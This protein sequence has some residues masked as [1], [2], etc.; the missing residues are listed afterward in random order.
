MSLLLADDLHLA[1]GERVIFE[2]AGVAIER[3]DRLGI[4]GPNG[5]G[6]S[7]LLEILAGQMAPDGGRVTRAKGVRVGYLAQE[8]GDPGDG[9]LLDS[10]L[11]TAPGRDALEARLAEVEAE[12]AAAE[13]TDRQ[14]EFAQEL[15]DLTA[16]IT[17]LEQDFA[18]HRAQRILV[19]L[20]FRNSDFD[21]PVSTFSGGWRMRAAL[22]ALLF[23]KP[24]VLLLDEPT[25][26][27]DMP[28][29]AWLSDFLAGVK[30]AVVLT[31]HDKEFLNRHVKRVASLELEGLRL[32]RGNYDEYLE[33]RELDIAHLEARAKKDEARK[34]ELEAFVERFR[35]KNTKARQAQSKLKLIEKMEAEVVELPQLRRAIS[36]RFAP[37]ERAADTVVKIEGLRFGYGAVRLFDGLS[38]EVRRGDRI[39]VVGV[40]GA[41]K[42]TLLELI[43]GAL[44]PEGGTISLGNK[45]TPRFFAQHHTEALNLNRSVLDEI[46]SAAPDLSQTAVRGLSGAFLF[47]GDD[48]DKNIA[49]LS[50]GEK[51]RVALAKILARP[52]NLLLLDEP[53]NH[54]DTESADKLTESLETY[55]GTTIFVSHN[56]DFARRLSNKVWDVHDGQV[57]VYPGSLAEYLEHLR[58]VARARDESLGGGF[59]AAPSKIAPGPKSTAPA[60]LPDDK[61]ARKEA[62]QAQRQ[63]QADHQKKL[64]S[65]ERRIEALEAEIATL[66]TEQAE[67]EATLADPSTHADGQRSKALS[68]RYAAVKASLDEKLTAWTEAS[69][70]KESLGA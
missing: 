35:A 20:G 38:L 8:H 24:D 1:F 19:G 50:G 2:G 17:A 40:N 31:C 12:L 67:L 4:V 41:G 13:D 62:R 21:R 66:E 6:K 55:D 63:A 16:Q 36:I 56:L 51:A 27:L 10:V 23:E 11:A 44:T 9:T 32:F 48:V 43:G 39:A 37:T 57:E 3:A 53:T 58:E 15:A 60:P 33:Q 45:V 34:K 69:A 25:N 18:P 7:T 54:L 14:M 28:S 42:T 68:D 46:W 29:V 49:V 64:R 30:Q 70:E 22:A 61:T 47:S 65:L 26:H 5:S 59:G 52:G